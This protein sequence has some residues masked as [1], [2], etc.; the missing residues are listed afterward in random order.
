M[1]L[2]L[3]QGL[4]DDRAQSAA[5]VEASFAAPEEGALAEE[6][7]VPAEAL[8]AD[9]REPDPLRDLAGSGPEEADPAAAAWQTTPVERHGTDTRP[10][11]RIVLPASGAPVPEPR[12]RRQRPPR[13]PHRGP[14]PHAPSSSSTTR[15]TCARSSG[16][17]S[18]PPASR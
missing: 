10:L 17:T 7:I 6:P 9:V 18:P 11:P 2:D 13:A 15:R 8:P 5:A 1:L 14:R 16:D 3:A 12:P 4:D